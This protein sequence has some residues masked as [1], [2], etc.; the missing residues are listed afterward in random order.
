MRCKCC[1]ENPYNDE[2]R[3]KHGIYCSCCD[4]VFEPLGEGEEPLIKDGKM[5]LPVAEEKICKNCHADPYNESGELHL[6]K[7]CSKCGHQPFEY[8]VSVADDDDFQLDLKKIIAWVGIGSVIVILSHPYR[9]APICQRSIC[10][11]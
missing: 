5:P 9:C 6:G 7:Y 3:L 4:H 10:L 1:G 2:G 8:E 11:V